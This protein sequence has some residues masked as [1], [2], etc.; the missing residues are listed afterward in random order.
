MK[1]RCYGC[2]FSVFL[3]GIFIA[4]YAVAGSGSI[5]AAYCPYGQNPEVFQNCTTTQ[6]QGSGRPQ[7]G[8]KVQLPSTVEAVSASLPANI[9]PEVLNLKLVPPPEAIKSGS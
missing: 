7:A 5:G 1:A 6:N 2:L 8:N 3:A 4:N 9:P